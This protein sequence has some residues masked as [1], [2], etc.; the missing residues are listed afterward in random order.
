MIA[1]TELLNKFAPISLEQMSEVRLM[2]RTDMKFV[3]NL[4]KLSQLLAMAWQ[5]YYV[6]DLG[7]ERNTEY[8]T[9]YFD[10]SD[11]V[12]YRHHQY[13]HANRQKIRF[14]TYVSSNKQF[15]EVKTKDNHGRTK[16]KR[17]EVDDM[18]LQDKE[19][20]QFLSRHLRYD[21]DTLQ[22]TLSNRFSRITLVNKGMTERLTIDS[23]L[24]FHNIVNG[25]DKDMDKLVIVELKRN[26][27]VYSPVL[28]MLRQ[29]RIQPHG[30][31]K[32]CMGSALTNPHLQVNRFKLKL[33]EVNK[34]VNNI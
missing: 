12:M 19:K 16:K 8:G 33:I 7:G 10:T 24:R 32:Y 31:S 5:E 25:M 22:P 21:V 29:L 6:Q 2:N 23:A 27:L 18:N 1:I 14:R 20:R 28:K 34:L 15:M 4:E 11:F 30:F 17:I 3:T 9:T 26:G 13:G